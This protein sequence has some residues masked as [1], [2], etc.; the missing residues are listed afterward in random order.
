MKVQVFATSEG[1]SEPERV[2]WDTDGISFY[3][4]TCANTIISNCRDLF[5]DLERVN[6]T[7]NTHSGDDKRARYVDFSHFRSYVNSNRVKVM[8]I[9]TRDQLADALTKPLDEE[10]FIHLRKELQGW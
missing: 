1:D 6:V 10:T 5:T 9:N 3:V 4:D 7:V 2:T 8:Y